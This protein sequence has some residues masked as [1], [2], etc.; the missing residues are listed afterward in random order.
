MLTGA[1]AA[2]VMLTQIGGGFDLPALA[3]IGGGG[4]WF[5]GF[6]ARRAS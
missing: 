4:A 1:R 3:L 5:A 2:P 6:L